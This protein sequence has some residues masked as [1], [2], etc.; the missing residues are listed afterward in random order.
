ML[1]YA[2]NAMHVLVARCKYAGVCHS[3]QT[4]LPRHI[5][6]LLCLVSTWSC[7]A[8]QPSE[9]PGV[10]GPALHPPANAKSQ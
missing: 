1:A 8:H 9:G 6:L 2:A 10:L 4:G 3:Q 5:L 7:K